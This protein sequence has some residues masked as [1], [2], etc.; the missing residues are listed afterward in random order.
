VVVVT[1]AGH[2]IGRA[3]GERFGQEGA[4]VVVNDVDEVRAHQVAQAIPGAIAVAADVSSK[5]QVDALF[6]AAVAASARS[7]CW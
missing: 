6:D 1:G 3:I 7:T 5:D 4:C 2:G